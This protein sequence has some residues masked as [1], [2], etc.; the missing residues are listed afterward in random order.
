[1]NTNQEFAIEQLKAIESEDKGNFEILKID[2]LKV[3][4]DYI[5]VNI[6]I[7]TKL[8]EKCTDGFNF[9][10]RERMTILIHTDFPY[11]IPSTYFSDY[12]Y[13]G[14]PHVQWGKKIC[15][16]QAPD[17]EWDPADGMFGYI[18]R[19][20][21]FLKKASLNQ[22]DLDDAPL[23]PP[24]AYLS[25][26]ID[27]KIIPNKNTPSFEG[28]FWLGATELIKLNKESLIISDW[29]DL[30][31]IKKS[32]LNAAAILMKKDMP[33]EYPSSLS[34]L[35]F[36][37]E[38]NGLDI[39][40]CIKH[41]QLVAE[42][43]KSTNPLIIIIGTPM[44]GPTINRK[45][46]LLAWYI[47]IKATRYLL[48]FSNIKRNINS[49]G[50]NINLEKF[51]EYAQKSEVQW[52]QILENREEIIIP[53]DNNSPTTYFRNKTIDL[54]GCGA[55][56]SHIAEFLVRVKPKKL[57]IFDNGIVKP[58]LLSRQ[59]FNE[60][61]IGENKAKALGNRINKIY[62][63]LHKVE[64][65]SYNLN[66]LSL[67]DEKQ[68]ENSRIII[69]TTASK[70]VL[71][72]LDGELLNRKLKGK[73]LSIVI[74]S[75]AMRG[76]IVIKADKSNCGIIDIIRRSHRVLC[77]NNNEQ[78]LSAF[79]PKQMDNSDSL[80]QPEPGCSDPTFYGSETDLST[81]SG[82]MLNCISRN[83]FDDNNLSKCIF[84][85]QNIIET[86]EEKYFETLVPEYKDYL[87]TDDPINNY[88]IFINE[89]AYKKIIK[90][91]EKENK[92]RHYPLET[93][94]L[95]FGGWD[96][97]NKVLYVD[98]V[99]G[100]PKDSKSSKNY[101]ECG[102]E[103]TKEYNEVIKKKYRNSSYFV[104]LWHSHPFGD[105]GF[106]NTDKVSMK[107]VVTKLSPPKS[108]LLIIAYNN[109][110]INLGGYVFNKS[111]FF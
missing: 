31:Q 28:D 17:V 27:Y 36:L 70:K 71:R 92:N 53:R 4:T 52:C 72:K 111:Q 82:L 76:M 23:H 63:H 103:G 96:D 75:K 84:V 46:H 97:L 16:Y 77:E 34:H 43:N 51:I 87:C 95:I 45:Q 109:K 105:K 21:L 73:I 48:G 35:I 25:A 49:I 56:G 64:I 106:S 101:F 58:G 18:S 74:D 94:G 33:F 91:I 110:N 67:L 14:K 8:Y 10:P 6:S 68:M 12:R 22:L 38:K 9:R 39:V 108:L 90:I 55:V 11:T 3:N 62:S 2:E 100:P 69:D 7:P 13:I 102:I 32:A 59:L 81:L 107:V 60:N 26:K 83:L 19:L 57:N 99:S 47:N 20:D 104:G 37:L 42:K 86:S 80:I 24:V 65:Q 5:F 50:R 79:F 54:W 98:E 88:K 41:L 66:I 78:W 29:K 44:R 1:M 40:K 61:D 89:E 15:L 93:G 30:K 85:S